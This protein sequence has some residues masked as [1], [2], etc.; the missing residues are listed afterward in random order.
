MADSIDYYR[1][2]AEQFYRD[3]I[4]ADMQALYAPFLAAIPPGGRVLDA[5]CGSGRDSLAF[6]RLGYSVQAF[7]AAPEMAGLAARL[8]AQPVPVLRF[9]ELAWKTEFDGVWACASLLHQPWA[10]LPCTLSQLAI[11][12][13]P[14]GVL[15]ASFKHGSG[16]RRYRN[17]HFTDLDQHRLHQ[18]LAQVPGLHLQHSWVTVDCRPDR[19]NQ[20]WLN[21]LLTA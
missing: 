13:K 20:E 4:G 18:L 7:D 6:L 5:G 9:D 19:P 8:L 1:E 15:Y 3:T 16:E 17:R 14:G 12:L 2:H 21:A 11:T 10:D